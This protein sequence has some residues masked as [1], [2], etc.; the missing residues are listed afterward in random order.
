MSQA[1]DEFLYGLPLEHEETIHSHLYPTPPSS[2]DIA[3][4]NFYTT[5]STFRADALD[6][7]N[8]DIASQSPSHAL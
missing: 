7:V 8:L 3:H 6:Q 2:R 5:I 4:M 1:D